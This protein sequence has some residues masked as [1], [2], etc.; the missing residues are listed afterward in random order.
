MTEEIHRLQ[1]SLEQNPQDREA[2]AALDEIY[3]GQSDWRALL[4]LYTKHPGGAPDG[5]ADELL[6]QRLR[7]IAS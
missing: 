4:D 6:A 2:F 3:Q 7:S 1:A 5:Q